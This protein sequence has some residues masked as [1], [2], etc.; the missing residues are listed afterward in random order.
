MITI[1]IEIVIILFDKYMKKPF[2][3]FSIMKID[4]NI[5][6]EY[7]NEIIYFDVLLITHRQIKYPSELL[8]SILNR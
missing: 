2:N 4:I 7:I 3:I 5:D 1:V 6:I 8:L